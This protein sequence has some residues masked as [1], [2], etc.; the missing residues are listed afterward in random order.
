MQF[1]SAPKTQVK[2]VQSPKMPID[3]T[4]SELQ[5][6]ARRQ[7]TDILAGRQ[8]CSAAI[9]YDGSLVLLLVEPQNESV[10]FPI[11]DQPGWATFP[12]TKSRQAYKGWLLRVD[13]SVKQ[14]VEVAT[15]DRAFPRIGAFASGDFLI[16]S[17]R[18]KFAERRAELNATIYSPSGSPL[19]QICLGDGIE[20]IAISEDAQ[21]WVSY[22][23]E[24]VFGNFGWGGEDAPCIGAPGLVRFDTHG[25][26]TWQYSEGFHC[27]DDC[28]SMTLT[29][30]EVWLCFYSDFPIAR[31]N[32]HGKVRFWE[33]PI[34]G[35]RAIAVDGDRVLLFGGY[36][37]DADR[38]VLQE[39]KETDDVSVPIYQGKLPVPQS[40]NFLVVT[41]R[42]GALHV[43][44][45]DCWY[46]LTV[47][48]ASA[49]F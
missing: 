11:F 12:E 28:Y 8:I 25:K 44:T 42:N 2:V 6:T 1:S 46:Q 40:K 24:G 33:N 21:I 16:A 41:G 7:L 34:A 36:G 14:E 10:P 22:F 47:R 49:H 9:A 38:L 13:D 32:T 20:D 4:E 23:D 26:Q 39:C 5:L 18:C 27:I 3:P 19:N 37:K 29:N 35:A 31:V 30:D 48:E 17:A 15:L 43:I 45:D